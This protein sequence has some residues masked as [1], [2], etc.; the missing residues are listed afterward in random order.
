MY[1]WLRTLREHFAL[2]GNLKELQTKQVE[3]CADKKTITD[4]SNS[5]NT[6]ESP[7]PE[8]DTDVITV[9]EGGEGEKV[10]TMNTE[11]TPTPAEESVVAQVT[12][13]GEGAKEDGVKTAENNSA[14]S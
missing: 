12:Q 7:L 1:R 11:E 10:D 3:V 9:P 8:G 4:S 5:A 13:G 2:N 6:E 14:G